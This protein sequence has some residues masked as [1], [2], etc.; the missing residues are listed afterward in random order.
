VRN[1]IECRVYCSIPFVKPNRWLTCL[2][3][4]RIRPETAAGLVERVCSAG[5]GVLTLISVPLCVRS[6]SVSVRIRMVELVSGIFQC[7]FRVEGLA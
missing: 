4:V 2:R 6:G 5:R 7:V 1:R 3:W